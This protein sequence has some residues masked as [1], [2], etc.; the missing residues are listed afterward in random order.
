MLQSFML[1]SGRTGM[2]PILNDP[3]ESLLARLDSSA[4]RW[5]IAM[6][7]LPGSGKSTLAARLAQAVNARTTAGT[8]AALGMDGFHLTKAELKALP[9]PE[10]ALA[11]RGAPWTFNPGALLERLQ[12]LRDGARRA[13]VDWPGFQHDVGD[14][15]EA[16]C[17]IA[18]GTRLILVEGIYLL[19]RADGWDAISVLFDER[20]YLDTPLDVAVERLT[21]RHMATLNLTREQAAARIAA[22]DRLNGEIVEKSKEFADYRVIA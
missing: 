21:Q 3:V 22:N 20:W 1:H 2:A 6:A 18:P 10:E 15:I 13:S 9:N 12:A 11:R 4:P 17:A 14:P 7:G 16:A 19:H 8:M 5:I